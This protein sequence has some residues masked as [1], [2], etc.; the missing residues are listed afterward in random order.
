MSVRGCLNYSG[1]QNVLLLTVCTLLVTIYFLLHTPVAH[2]LQCI[3]LRLP[4]HCC[5]LQ[6][7]TS[8]QQCGCRQL[9]L[10]RLAGSPHLLN[11][12]LQCLNGLADNISFLIVCEPLEGIYTCFSLLLTPGTPEFLQLN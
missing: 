6:A 12:C 4:P 7:L 5:I 3:T 8:C 2:A 10:C 9:L 11:L 1:C